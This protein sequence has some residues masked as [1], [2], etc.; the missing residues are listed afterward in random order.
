MCQSPAR[1]LIWSPRPGQMCVT[2]DSLSEADSRSER[3]QQQLTS[4][5]WVVQVYAELLGDDFDPD[6]PYRV[7]HG[8]LLKSDLHKQYDEYAWS[9]Y[10]KVCSY[11]VFYCGLVFLFVAG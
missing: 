10:T 3:A 5:S 7:S 6:Y 2:N 11:R 8:V 1:L 9:F 4:T